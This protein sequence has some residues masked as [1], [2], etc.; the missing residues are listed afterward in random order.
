VTRL[1]P[2][3]D[4]LYYIRVA[5]GPRALDKSIDPHFFWASE[6]DPVGA[7][8][9]EGPYYDSDLELAKP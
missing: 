9:L 5:G 3:V 6:P 8:H 2:L 4:D 1:S 7:T